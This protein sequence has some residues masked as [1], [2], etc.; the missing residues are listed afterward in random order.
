MNKVIVSLLLVII[1]LV[2]T[3]IVL[4][5]TYGENS[6]DGRM[7]DIMETLVNINKIRNEQSNTFIDYDDALLE[8]IKLQVVEIQDLKK[9]VNILKG[10][11]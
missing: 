1:V 8:I 6:V 2:S 11:E 9:E 10:N 3:D 5:F 7:V 4:N